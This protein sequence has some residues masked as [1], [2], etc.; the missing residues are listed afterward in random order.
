[1]LKIRVQGTTKDIKWFIK[2]LRR[3]KRFSMLNISDILDNK[4]TIRYKRAYAE[5]HRADTEPYI[6]KNSNEFHR[7]SFGSGK[8]FSYTQNR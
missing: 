2:L 4:G 6:N 8:N 7:G 3:D 1:M 5:I